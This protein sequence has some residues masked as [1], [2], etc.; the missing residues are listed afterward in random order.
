MGAGP[1]RASPAV[2]SLQRARHPA[3]VQ[4][5][6]G[7]VQPPGA[8]GLPGAAAPGVHGR[9]AD[10]P[11]H[12]RDG[13]V[14]ARR[15]AAPGRARVR[16]GRHRLRAERA[17]RRVAGLA[18]GLGDGV[19]RV[20][21]RRHRGGAAGA[22]PRPRRDRPRPR[23]RRHG[24]RRA[25]RHPGAPGAGDGALRRGVPGAAG[26]GPGRVG[27]RAAPPRRRGGGR[28]RRPRPRR[29][30]VPARGA[31]RPDVGARRQ[32]PEPDPL[33][34]RH[35]ALPRARL[36]RPPRDRQSMV[37]SRLL[38]P[39]RRLRGRGGPGPRRRGRRR[40][41]PPPGPVSRGRAH[42]RGRRGVRRGGVRARRAV[43]A[44]GAPRR[45]A[46]HLEPGAA[47]AR[48][49]PRRPGRGGCRRRRPFLGRRRRAALDVG[50]LRGRRRGAGRG[51]ARRTG[52]PA[53]GPGRHPRPRL[54]VAVGGGSRRAGRARPGR[55]GPRP[56]R[57]AGPA[58]R[59]QD[60]GTP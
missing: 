44:R 32:G 41:R 26:P 36:R 40:E 46:D 27:S 14:R 49:R 37:R 48:L 53:P 22:A 56:P 13:R 42:G 45:G 34:V 50:G 11:R 15:R 28:G 23:R 17:V 20:G 2:E 12:R 35:G 8:G 31:A 57:G 24:V 47:P 58:S 25:A 18:R 39:H 1:P 55:R 16:H 9:G 52:Q 54:P 7:V 21:V 6:G 5:A 60:R 3:R 4:L 30:P 43:A 29:A 10:G 59:A 38:R 51:V 33:A 19:G